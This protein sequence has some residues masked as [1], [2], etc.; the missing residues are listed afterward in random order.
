MSI[1]ATKISSSAAMYRFEKLQGWAFSISDSDYFVFHSPYNKLVQKSFSRLFFNYFLRNASYADESAKEKLSA[2][3]HLSSEESYQSR[4]LEKASQQVAKPLYDSKVQPSTLL[5]KQVGNMYTASLYAAFAPLLHNI[6]NHCI[7]V[8]ICLGRQMGG[9]TTTIFSLKL[10]D[11][12]HPF[13]LLNIAKMMNVSE[14]LKLR[15]E[16][17]KLMDHRYGSKDFVT[18]KDCSF[19]FPGTFYLTEV[20]SMYPIFYT[21]KADATTTILSTCENDFAS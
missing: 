3:S 6:I 13:K 16:T 14:K 19:L 2:F 8:L 12:Q 9:L 20:D 10:Q 4:D 7:T 18:S 15:H 17:M 11:G 21:W 1:C 5:P